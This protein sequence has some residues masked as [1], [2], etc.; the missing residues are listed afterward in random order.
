MDHEFRNPA[1]VRLPKIG[2]GPAMDEYGSTS[3]ATDCRNLSNGIP[4]QLCRKVSVH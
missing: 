4:M 2:K 1:V 3:V